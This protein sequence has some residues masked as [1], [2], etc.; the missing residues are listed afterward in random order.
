MRNPY[1][2]FIFLIA[3]SFSIAQE[4]IPFRLTQHNNIIISTLV[5][6]KDSLDLMFQIS[7]KDAAISPNRK[8][9][10][11]SIDFQNEISENN[12]VKMGNKKWENIRFFE[13]EYSGHESDGKIG[14]VL[15][16]NQIFAI[17]YDNNQFVI[18][19]SLP[20]VKEYTAIPLL[21]DGDN[22]L[23]V[24]DNVFDWQENEIWFLMQSGFSGAIMYSNEEAK[25]R[26]LA[27]KLKITHEQEFQ[28]S[29]GNKVFSK[30]GILPFLQF[31]NTVFQ[32]VKIG[33]FEGDARVQFWNYF[34]AD[35]MKRFNWIFDVENETAY[36][37][38][39]KYLL[40]SFYEFE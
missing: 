32:D 2:L 40:H 11:T 6:E 16:G 36:I 8:N 13:N 9:P 31:G 28:D 39:S 14:K 23:V 22:F 29:Q 19:E 17:D 37:K 34:G 12:S 10:V 5:N 15:F 27:Q 21:V 35:L 38:P 4:T 33:F 26:Q 30:Q 18:Y 3:S 24:A 1:F 7:M 25:E 20:N